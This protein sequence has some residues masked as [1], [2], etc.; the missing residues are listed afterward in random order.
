[1]D[2]E[3][4]DVQLV[5]SIVKLLVKH[6]ENV[7]VT[8]TIDD[9]GVLLTLRVHA[10]DMAGIVGREGRTAKAIRTLLRVIGAQND[11][12]VNLKIV[13][14]HSTEDRPRTAT[15]TEANNEDSQSTDTIYSAATE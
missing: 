14:P 5:T 10:E 7:E 9:L 1:M 8:R 12:R 11:E 6:P 4:K 15:N 13:E 3:Q 2:N